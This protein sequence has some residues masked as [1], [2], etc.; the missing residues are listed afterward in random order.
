MY[1][2][3]QAYSSPNIPKH[4]GPEPMQETY[5]TKNKIKTIE[6]L[7]DS[8]A[9]NLAK[10]YQLKPEEIVPL[11]LELD[12]ELAKNKGKI[13]IDMT[14]PETPLNIFHTYWPAAP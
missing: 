9:K 12:R 14:N 11:H 10:Q 13:H 2:E 5:K 3:Y 8:R 1:I 7:V 4:T 6:D